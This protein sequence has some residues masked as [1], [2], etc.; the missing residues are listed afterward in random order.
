[1]NRDCFVGF[2]VYNA[3]IRNTYNLDQNYIMIQ[4]MVRPEV[5]GKN[6]RI[7]RTNP[8]IRGI[9]PRYHAKGYSIK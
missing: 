2:V 7:K 1:M 6:L 9:V 5:M 4:I 3:S 8:D